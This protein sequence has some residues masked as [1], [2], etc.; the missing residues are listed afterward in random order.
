MMKNFVKGIVLLSSLMPFAS[1]SMNVVDC[2][3]VV[4]KQPDHVDEI[5]A[6]YENKKDGSLTRT[7]IDKL[8]ADGMADQFQEKFQRGATT[9]PYGIIKEHYTE[10]G[11]GTRVRCGAIS[12]YWGGPEPSKES[13]RQYIGNDDEMALNLG[14]RNHR[15]TDANAEA[16]LMYHGSWASLLQSFFALERQAKTKKLPG[17]IVFVE[18]SNSAKQRVPK[19]DAAT[20]NKLIAKMMPGVDPKFTED[21][22]PKTMKVAFNWLLCSNAFEEVSKI[23][24]LFYQTIEQLHSEDSV[25]LKFSRI[26]PKCNIFVFTASSGRNYHLDQVRTKLILPS[27]IK[28]VPGCS[29]YELGLDG[30]CER[31]TD[32]EFK[33]Q[34]LIARNYRISKMFLYLDALHALQKDWQQTKADRKDANY[35]LLDEVDFFDQKY[36]EIGFEVAHQLE[37]D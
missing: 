15:T 13:I 17:K 1:F 27:H 30:F 21:T 2:K 28:L 24:A 25:F 14:L 23:N 34:E 16:V 35:V 10:D 20:I 4:E 37:V 26:N 18:P 31:G 33:V 12:C 19:E 7:M 32:R 29:H 3:M 6:K 9:I 5:I 11:L 36:K 8:K 22:K